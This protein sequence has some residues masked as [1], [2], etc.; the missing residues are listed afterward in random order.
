MKQLGNLG[1]FGLFIALLTMPLIGF[2]FIEFEP[3][4]PIVLPAKD[5]RFVPAVVNE[6][7]ETSEVTESTLN[8]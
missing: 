4:K 1:L 6:V 7:R 3:A 5:V 8:H 2:G